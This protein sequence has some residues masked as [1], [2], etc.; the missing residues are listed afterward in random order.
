MQKMDRHTIK[1]IGNDK[2]AG[3]YIL[4]I[5]LAESQTLQIGRFKK[6][7]YIP[8]TSGDYTYVGSALAEKRFTPRSKEVVGNLFSIDILLHMKIKFI[9]G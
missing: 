7:K 4:R 9:I 8:L 2:Q 5:R 3:T 1:I 6:G